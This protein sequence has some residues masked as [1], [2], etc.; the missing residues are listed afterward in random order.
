MGH[1]SWKNSYP[2]QHN[3]ANNN[4]KRWKKGSWRH[5]WWCLPISYWL[6]KRRWSSE[7]QNELHQ[8]ELRFVFLHNNISPL[9]YTVW[10]HP[11]ESTQEV[12]TSTNLLQNHNHHPKLLGTR[13]TPLPA[14]YKCYTTSSNKSWT[15]RLG[16]S[17][18]TFYYKAFL[19][20]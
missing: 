7:L 15:T 1:E 12:S 9:Y 8:I 20:F 16:G 18:S 3:T 4:T 5:Y 19:K 13:R 6:V 17:S 11:L 2:I 14:K 10:L